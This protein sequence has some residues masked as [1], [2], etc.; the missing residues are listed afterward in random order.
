MLT[1][2]RICKA[3]NNPKKK[4]MLNHQKKKKIKEIN[5]KKQINLFLL[6]YFIPILNKNI[7]Y[8]IINESINGKTKSISQEVDGYQNKR[9]RTIFK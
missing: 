9:V 1:V 7:S 6:V 3:K 2:K 5:K 4:K 8:Y